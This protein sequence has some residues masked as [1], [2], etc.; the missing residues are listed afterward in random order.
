MGI[1]ILAWLSSLDPYWLSTPSRANMGPG[2]GMI[3]RP[4][5]KCPCINLYL[6]FNSKY[7]RQ[8]INVIFLPKINV[9][10]QNIKFDLV[11][12]G[13]EVIN[14]GQLAPATL[15]NLSYPFVTSGLYLSS[16]NLISRSF[17]CE[18]SWFLNPFTVF[19]SITFAGKLFQVST[20]LCEKLYF[21]ILVLQCFLQILCLWPLV[22][23]SF[24]G[25]ILLLF[26][27]LY[28]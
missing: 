2:L 12:P 9:V 11:L 24:F 28:C 15:L 23:F 17:Q 4:I 6:L 14:V 27:Y 20:T 5:W 16:L 1:S 10:S 7:K 19:D 21:L 26:T 18:F 22:V 8:W 13:V 25:K 3:T